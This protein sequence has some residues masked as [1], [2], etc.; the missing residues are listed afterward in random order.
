MNATIGGIIPTYAI[1]GINGSLNGVQYNQQGLITWVVV[2][3]N[4]G[5][6]RVSISELSSNLLQIIQDWHGQIFGN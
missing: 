6:W 5:V 3:S 2:K 4:T 1:P